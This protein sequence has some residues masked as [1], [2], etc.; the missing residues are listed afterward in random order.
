MTR[1]LGPDPVLVFATS[2]EGHTVAIAVSSPEAPEELRS[3]GILT[4]AQ[5]PE[6]RKAS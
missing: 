6:L 5:A 2:A 1:D 3:P 4:T